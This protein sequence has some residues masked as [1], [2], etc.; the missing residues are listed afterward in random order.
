MSSSLPLLP[1]PHPLILF[2]AARISFPVPN[3]LADA[4][5]PLIEA[6]DTLP[7][8]AAVPV[9]PSPTPSLAH[10]GTAARVLRITRP[11]SRSF[12]HPSVITLHGLSRVLIPGPRPEPADLQHTLV[13][14]PVQYSLSYEQ[15]PDHDVVVKFKEAALRLLD[16]MARDSPTPHKRE[17]YLK[18]ASMMDD[19]SD[20][21][22]P[23]MA[24]VLVSF[25]ADD[26][27]DKLGTSIFSLFPISSPDNISLAAILAEQ[28]LTTRLTL[29]TVLFTKHTS[30]SEVS[31]KI[32]SAVDE[33]LSRQQKEFFLRQQ[34]AAI[35]RELQSLNGSGNGSR[36][37]NQAANGEPAQ[38]SGSEL[39][40][41]DA[42][43]SS[44]LAELKAK[45]EA[46]LPGSEERKMGVRDWRRLKRIPAGS[47]E[48]GVVRSYVRGHSSPVNF[49]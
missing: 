14:H 21:R 32:A 2:P 48:N 31:K 41:D 15:M 29:A 22:A 13:E 20:Q 47:V 19:V 9:V 11:S 1:L 45:I 43:E 7:V 23:W 6:S 34:L 36:S 4:I 42:H 27:D 10:C 3:T 33:S 35:Q 44:D 18:I 17:S 28:S 8:I 5:I 12:R 40:D 30:I 16:R 38:T 26:Y 25:V 49:D 24:D 46:M 39:D 37:P